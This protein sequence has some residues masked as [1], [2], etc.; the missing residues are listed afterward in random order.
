[1]GRHG[2]EN[3]VATRPGFSSSEGGQTWPPFSCGAE[4]S[5]VSDVSE[6]SEVRDNAKA[7]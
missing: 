4:V 6:V 3:K 1:M 7:A 5:E 2:D